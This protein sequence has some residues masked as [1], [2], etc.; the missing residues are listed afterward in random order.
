[1]VD[2]LIHPLEDKYHEKLLELDHLK[3][4][5][6][7]H[8]YTGEKTF[9]VD[10]LIGA[11]FYWSFIGDEKPIR[12]QGPTAINS[13]IGY[14]VSCPLDSVQV[15]KPVQAISLHIQTVEADDWS[16]LWSLETLGIFPH[17]EKVKEA[18]DYAKR[19][20][21]FNDGQYTARFPWKTDHLEL[22]T[23]YAMVKAMTRSTV[24]RLG[25]DGML[26]VFADLIK[27]QQDRRF[28]EQVPT[29]Q[30]SKGCH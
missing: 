20:V 10:L 27:D 28:I 2:Y 16:H 7:A 13:K 1:M 21:E 14:L 12:G 15:Q 22:L 29:D 5:N 3:N 19:C 17:L 4:L 25:R 6:L 8:L 30:L 9:R 18:A 23:N 11:D 26:K 24:K